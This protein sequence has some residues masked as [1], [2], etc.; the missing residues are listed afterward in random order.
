MTTAFA[1]QTKNS[2][3]FSNSTRHS[4]T[5][6]NAVLPYRLFGDLTMQE[7]AAYAFTDVFPGTEGGLQILACTFET[8]VFGTSYTNQEKH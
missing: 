4:S 3:S 8:R 7:L 1:N 2:S 5:F 6:S